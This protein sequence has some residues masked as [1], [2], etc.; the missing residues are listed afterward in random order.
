MTS[1][2]KSLFISDSLIKSLISTASINENS[3]FAG[4][5]WLFVQKKENVDDVFVA[6]CD[7]QQLETSRDLFFLL[8][9]IYTM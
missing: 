9:F 2:R 5:T 3:T 6:L 4:S 8:L 1:V 7:A